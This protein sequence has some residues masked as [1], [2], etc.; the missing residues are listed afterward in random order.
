M[1]RHGRRVR[2]TWSGKIGRVV[3]PAVP[4]TPDDAEDG[5]PGVLVRLDPFLPTFAGGIVTA[6]AEKR[7]TGIEVVYA[8]ED[9][10]LL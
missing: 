8:S 3:A 9:L 5:P 6:R 2:V 7:L 4:R 10:E 1:L